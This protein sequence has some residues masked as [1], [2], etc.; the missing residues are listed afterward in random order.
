MSAQPSSMPSNALLVTL[1]P[2]GK[3]FYLPVVQSLG[4]TRSPSPSSG[5]NSDPEVHTSGNPLASM[6]AAPRRKD[7]FLPKAHQS[8]A[9]Y[10]A[11]ST[12][13]NLVKYVLKREQVNSA[14]NSC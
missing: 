10:A 9:E 5:Y 14:S 3:T 7:F 8:R 11:S 12:W 13:Q 1:S 6:S 4:P 2:P